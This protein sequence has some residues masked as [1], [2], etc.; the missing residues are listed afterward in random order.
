MSDEHITSVDSS[1]SSK[2][3]EK[4]AI[5]NEESTEVSEKTL[6]FDEVEDVA[7]ILQKE[8]RTRQKMHEEAIKEL[9]NDFARKEAKFTAHEEKVK[10]GSPPKIA[11][12]RDVNV[13]APDIQ[14]MLEHGGAMCAFGQT[15]HETAHRLALVAAMNMKFLFHP[16]V[17]DVLEDRDKSSADTST[18]ELKDGA[19]SVAAIEVTDDG[20]A[21]N[22]LGQRG[23][24]HAF[25]HE[26]FG[27]TFP[28][29]VTV[30]V[31][32]PYE[33][34]K[35]VDSH[36]NI[37]IGPL[38][39][40][41][42]MIKRGD[43]CYGSNRLVI[44]GLPA[45]AAPD[46]VAPKKV[47]LLLQEG[48]QASF[49]C[50][51]DP[52]TLNPMY[53]R[54]AGRLKH[55]WRC[56]VKGYGQKPAFRVVQRSAGGSDVTEVQQTIAQIRKPCHLS[57]DQM[58]SESKEPKKEP[59][60]NHAFFPVAR[61]AT[62]RISPAKIP[63]ANLPT[64]KILTAKIP[65]ANLPT[66]KIQI[67]KIPTAKSPVAWN[68]VARI[69]TA[70]SPVAW[71]P[72]ARIPVFKIPV[73]GVPKNTPHTS[74]RETPVLDKW[75]RLLPLNFQCAT[76]PFSP[77]QMPRLMCGQGAILTARA[78]VHEPADMAQSI[79]ATP[80]PLS[81]TMRHNH[82]IVCLPPQSPFGLSSVPPTPKS[83]VIR[84]VKVP[85]DYFSSPQSAK[86]M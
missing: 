64:A 27:V 67:A 48:Q 30:T 33:V 46:D 62:S 50:C 75:A 55:G 63:T 56:N 53:D 54:I 36:A 28:D 60:S 45:H 3:E 86:R 16:V 24:V 9:R 2:C 20:S 34:A 23:N 51:D 69:P 15:A 80:R 59:C 26:E 44:V 7:E 1:A 38:S 25:H 65:I 61:N 19:V 17:I 21:I 42:W 10:N 72:V 14:R 18:G 6:I 76:S 66:A 47:A 74:L 58:Y 43:C 52:K 71:T 8:L 5:P 49:I 11:F 29:L 22:L 31:K 79:S 35:V 4:T 73:V 83:Y 32:N 57:Y 40:I 77:R 84:E 37:S 82:S 39:T 78:P 85:S 70:K 81:P 13:V 68:P 12:S 41:V